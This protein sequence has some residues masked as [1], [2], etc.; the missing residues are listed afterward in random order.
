MSDRKR[1]FHSSFFQEETLPFLVTF[2]KMDTFTLPFWEMF[3]KMDTLLKMILR[4]LVCPTDVGFLLEN[5]QNN[6][7]MYKN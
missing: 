2:P 1:T 5:F 3:P 7:K 6:V 4:Y